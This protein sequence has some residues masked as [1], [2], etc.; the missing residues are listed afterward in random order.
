[1]R[2]GQG[3]GRG[4][5]LPTMASI[6]SPHTETG[7][8]PEVLPVAPRDVVFAPTLVCGTGRG[9]RGRIGRKQGV[10]QGEQGGQFR[11]ANRRPPI[12]TGADRSGSRTRWMEWRSMPRVLGLCFGSF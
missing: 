10:V 7:R 12:V 3:E 2:G 9:T 11:P 4:Q 6:A 1:M 8:P 5:A